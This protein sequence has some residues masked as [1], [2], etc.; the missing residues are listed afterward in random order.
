M[1]VQQAAHHL[2]M[3]GENVHCKKTDL[4][5]LKIKNLQHYVMHSPIYRKM[6]VYYTCV[7]AVSILSASMMVGNLL[8]CPLSDLQGRRQTLTLASAAITT[9]WL[10]I[11]ATEGL[12]ML[13]VGRVIVGVGVGLLDPTSHVMLSEITLIR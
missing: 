2:W 11:G 3:L 8:S 7:F 9:G 13:L 5:L 1:M 12:P 4:T 6:Q 10:A